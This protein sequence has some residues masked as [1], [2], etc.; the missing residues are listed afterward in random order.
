MTIP[1]QGR[2]DPFTLR[3]LSMRIY[4][5]SLQCRSITESHAHV[6]INA[7]RMKSRHEWI[8]SISTN[9]GLEVSRSNVET[10]PVL[11]ER[12]QTNDL[13]MEA[14]EGT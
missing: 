5:S 4:L 3:G 10:I 14:D 6:T 7:F 9:P 8:I 11:D 2:H 1:L 12:E 13:C